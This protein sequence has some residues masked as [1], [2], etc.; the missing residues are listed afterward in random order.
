MNENRRHPADSAGRGG[1]LSR[2]IGNQDVSTPP[3]GI[4]SSSG[5]PV[6]LPVLGRERAN[7]VARYPSNELRRQN[8][9]SERFDG[10][11]HTEESPSHSSTHRREPLQAEKRYRFDPI[12]KAKR[13]PT[14]LRL[15]INAKCWECQGG[16]LDPHPRWRIGNCEV[17]DCS[18]YPNRPYQKSFGT[19]TPAPLRWL[20]DHQ[21]RDHGKGRAP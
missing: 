9:R 15:A 6:R 10:P 17:V 7:S 14:S 18:L 1:V 2:T 12:E 3:A 13:K 16:N 11:E 21:T 4:H 19:P 8:D 5:E 20:D